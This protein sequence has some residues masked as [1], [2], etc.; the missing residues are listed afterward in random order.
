MKITY[1]LV[2][3]HVFDSLKRIGYNKSHSFVDHAVLYVAASRKTQ[4]HSQ[5]FWLTKKK[6]KNKKIA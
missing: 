3:L 2:P 6:I 5:F 1:T 4:D